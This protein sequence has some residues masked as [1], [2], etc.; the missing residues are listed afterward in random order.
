MKRCLTIAHEDPIGMDLSEA[1]D[2]VAKAAFP[3]THDK[4]NPREDLAMMLLDGI[5]GTPLTTPDQRRS[6][7]AMAEA[8]MGTTWVKLYLRPGRPL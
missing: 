5:W 2:Y 3:P 6:A 8:L 1:W 4:A 7:G